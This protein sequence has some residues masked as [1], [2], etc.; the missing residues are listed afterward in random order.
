MPY[1]YYDLRGRFIRARPIISFVQ[2]VRNDHT[3]RVVPRRTAV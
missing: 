2:K 1:N 3:R